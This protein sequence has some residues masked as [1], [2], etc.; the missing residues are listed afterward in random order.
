M[1]SAITNKIGFCIYVDTVCHGAVPIELNERGKP[2]V[3][4]TLL[5]AQR[6]IVGNTIIRLQQFLE[7]ERDYEDAMSTEEYIV[8][9]DVF[10]DGSIT[11]ASEN[12]FGAS[13]LSL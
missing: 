2:I 3:Y 9:V 12:F 11:D 4:P 5:D 6:K 1:N 8:E 13:D 7:G 10:Q